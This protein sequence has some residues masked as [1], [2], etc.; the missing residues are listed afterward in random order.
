MAIGNIP[1]LE[2]A[3]EILK[4]RPAVTHLIEAFAIGRVKMASVLLRDLCSR[5]HEEG[6]LGSHPPLDFFFAT[7]AL[8]RGIGRTEVFASLGTEPDLSTYQV[9]GRVFGLIPEYFL[10]LEYV[11]H[12]EH[13][14]I[15]GV[16]EEI[17]YTAQEMGCRVLEPTLVKGLLSLAAGKIY[18]T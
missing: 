16:M 17:L 6:A 3:P 4:T 15:P 11:L 9:L 12:Q 10:G 7:F 14:E 2:E 13:K 18:S 5:L 1:D 8:F